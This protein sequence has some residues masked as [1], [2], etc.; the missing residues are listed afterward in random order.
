MHAAEDR[1]VALVVGA[2]DEIGEAIARHLAST[3]ARL[4]LTAADGRGFDA[5]MDSLGD[6][7]AMKAQVDPADARAV[8]DCVVEVLARYGRIDILV[9]NT[10]VLEGKP[11][12]AL[13]AADIDATVN[14]ALAGPFRF[15]IEVVPCMQRNGYGRVVNVS[16]LGWL[17]LPNQAN[18]AAARAGLFGLTRSVALESAR[19]G[20]TVN[21]V[22]KGD[23]ATART[24]DVQTEQ[25]ASGIPVKRLGTPAD[26]ARAVAYF[27]A[28]SSSYVTG[29]TLFVCGAKSVH[30]SMSV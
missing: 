15:M 30:F 9:N 4:A 2:N 17:G 23:I 26:V 11:L 18:V 3:G 22:V 28:E 5:L 20:V 14:E 21:T 8:A 12:S 19:S 10:G 7:D 16:E 24:T 29:Q 6:V 1:R 25:L 13:S 27:A